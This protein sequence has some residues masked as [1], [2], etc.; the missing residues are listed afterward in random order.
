[1]RPPRY[2][3]PKLVK[4]KVDDKT[5]LFMEFFSKEL[6]VKFVDADAGEE[7]EFE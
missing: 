5:K 3:R 4:R 7:V 2:W 6:G 1:M